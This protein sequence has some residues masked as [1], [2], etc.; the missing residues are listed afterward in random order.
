MKRRLATVAVIVLVLTATAGC[1][2]WPVPTDR[3]QAS[4]SISMG[5]EGG[6]DVRLVLG[7]QIREHAPLMRTGV[8]V[9]AALFP[10][11]KHSVS[12]DNNDSGYPFVHVHA[13]GFYQRGPQPTV[14]IDT[15]SAL[16]VLASMGYRNVDV[17]ISAPLVPAMA[18]WEKVPDSVYPGHW[19][20]QGIAPGDT[21]PAGTVELRPNPGRIDVAVVLLAA[22][23]ASVFVATLGLRRRRRLVAGASAAVA[24]AAPALY[25]QTVHPNDLG[26]A[27]LVNGL[28]LNLLQWLPLASGV[29]AI[30]VVCIFVVTLDR[31]R[32]PS[33]VQDFNAPPGWPQAPPGWRPVPGWRP[34][35]SWPPAP[36]GWTFYPPANPYAP[37]APKRMRRPAS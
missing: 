9:A 33:A 7:G 10:T 15:R 29:T 20:W 17:D 11:S 37:P 30:A 6:A 18:Q 4:M 2:P 3:T 22:S 5:S 23:L 26:V 13:T 28:Q 1:E 36:L 12:V 34:D 14:S 24:L 35:P 16:A 25:T 8:A 21:A 32:S 27:G 31:T 19:Y